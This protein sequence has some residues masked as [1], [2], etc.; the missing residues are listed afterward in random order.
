MHYYYSNNICITVSCIQTVDAMSKLFSLT[1]VQ[2]KQM[3]QKR[4]LMALLP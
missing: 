4:T 3:W 2:R 1:V